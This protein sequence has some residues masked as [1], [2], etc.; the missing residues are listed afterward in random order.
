MRG[1]QKKKKKKKEQCK[2]RNR[3]LDCELHGRWLNDSPFKLVAAYV[4]NSNEIRVTIQ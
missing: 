4:I 1:F 2:N 3:T